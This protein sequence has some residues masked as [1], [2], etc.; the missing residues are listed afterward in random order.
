MSAGGT[1]ESGRGRKRK[2][3]DDIGAEAGAGRL[4]MDDD[5]QVLDQIQNKLAGGSPT[6][7]ALRENRT[8]SK[9]L[10]NGKGLVRKDWFTNL[11]SWIV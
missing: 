6:I 9:F 1:V 11:N 7:R 4:K 8:V 3:S 10:R 2:P 5:R